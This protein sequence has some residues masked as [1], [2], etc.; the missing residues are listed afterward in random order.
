[1]S[2]IV[3][4]RDTLPC[5]VCDPD[6]LPGIRRVAAMVMGDVE[7]VFGAGAEKCDLTPQELQV[8]AG[9]KLIF[10]VAGSSAL[11]DDM[12]SRGIIDISGISGK[13]EV[14]GFFPVG[15]DTLVIAGSDKRGTIYGLFHLSELMDV[16]PFVNWS[17]LMPAKKDSLVL[18]DSHLYISKEPSV[19]YRG[20]FIND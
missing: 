15:D 8:K 19:E 14:Y 3:L 10:G 16:S 20:F 9:V 6:C 7:K 17:A 5:F 4:S 18:D 1:M 12:A 11:I 2:R 13:R